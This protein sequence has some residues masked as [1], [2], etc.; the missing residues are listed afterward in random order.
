MRFLTDFGLKSNPQSKQWHTLLIK[1]NGNPKS[2]TEI[3]NARAEILGFETSSEPHFG[4]IMGQSLL[5][6]LND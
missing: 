2:K 4:Q 1:G 6:F 3:A 5:I